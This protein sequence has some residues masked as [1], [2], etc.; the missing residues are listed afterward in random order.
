M[1]H[2]AQKPSPA[3]TPP[4]H[5]PGGPAVDRWSLVAV[6]GMLSFVAMLDM[7]IV[8]VALADIS[9]SLNVSPATAQWALLG[10]Q[11]PVVAL[12]LPIGRWLD[13]AAGLRP[14]LLAATAGFAVCSMAAAAAPWAAWLIGARACQ[15]VFAAVLFVL[16]PV[17]AARSVRPELRARALSVP[18]TCGPLGAVTGPAVGGILLDHLG[19]RAV[20]LVK[21]PFCIAALV[22]ARRAMPRDGRL[23][24]PDRRSLAD[25]ALVGTA[26]AAVLLALTLAPG[27]PAWLLLATAAAPPL[28][29]WLRGPGG[30]TF[31]AALRESRMHG[32]YGAVLT[33]AAGFAATRYAVALHLQ[34]DDGVSA[35]TT[36]L[37]VLAFPLGMGLAGPLGGRLATR[38][39]P[40][41][42]AVSGAAITTLGLGLLLPLGE[43]LSPPEVAWRLALAGIG[44]G[45]YGGP[46]QALV[47]GAAPP[48]RAATAASTIQLSRQLGF[49]LGPALAAALWGSAGQAHGVQA[50]LALAAAAA[51]LAIPLLA[52]R[53]QR[54]ARTG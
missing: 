36:G 25:A 51:G 50:A 54:F 34:Q 29:L 9:R 18:A 39:G 5:V 19:W 48:G 43:T 42:V 35:T 44:M 8:T 6:A 24:A 20:L 31:T 26:L 46:A 11:L 47:M 22:A 52:L 21:L 14:A 32:A 15:G 13:G 41:P 10:Y 33:L 1:P 27:A 40:R 49:A 12:L 7:N 30:R 38:F 45:L 16:M 37:T 23:R 17:L 28:A 3:R 2:H 4:S 53:H